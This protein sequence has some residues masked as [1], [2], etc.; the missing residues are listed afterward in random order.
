MASINW[1]GLAAGGGLEIHNAIR[2]A[3]QVSGKAVEG[4]QA[5]RAGEI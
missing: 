4:Q 5:H 1:W 2:H 3:G